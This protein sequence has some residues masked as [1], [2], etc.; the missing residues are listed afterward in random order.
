MTGDRATTF[1]TRL[2]CDARRAA[3]PPNELPMMKKCGRATL[4][5]LPVSRFTNPRLMPLMTSRM[6]LW[7]D[8]LRNTPPLSQVPRY[9]GRKTQYPLAAKNGNKSARRPGY[10]G[11]PAHKIKT[12]FD[13]RVGGM[14]SHTM[15]FANLA[16]GVC[17]RFFFIACWRVVGL[18]RTLQS[19]RRAPP[20]RRA[21]VLSSPRALQRVATFPTHASPL[22]LHQTP[23]S[24][25]GAS[26]PR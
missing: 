18:L 1:S 26:P 7:G 4:Y 21:S 5:L 23:F 24:P 25:D 6:S 15:S 20:L 9:R 19:R 13:F 10:T 22:F 12:L 17:S 14:N 3:G 2:S 16:L 8:F 11:A